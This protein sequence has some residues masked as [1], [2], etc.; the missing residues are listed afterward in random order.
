LSLAFGLRPARLRSGVAQGLR[1]R[2]RPDGD[3][4]RA[5]QRP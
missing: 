3:P 5:G 4:Y 2:Q 1:Y